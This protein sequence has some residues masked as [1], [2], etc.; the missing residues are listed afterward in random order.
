MNRPVAAGLR[1]YRAFARAFPHEFK[2]VYGEEM[3]RAAEDSVDGI[4]R[5]HGLLG[6]FRL[7]AD[8][9]LQIP[10]EY[11]AEL[12]QDVRYGFRML[13]RAP[14]PTAVALLSLTLGIGV[15]ISAFSEMNGFVLRDVPGVEDPSELVMPA[16]PV[17]FPDYRRYRGQSDL[18]SST[19]AYAAPVPFGV[20]LG[21]RTERTWGHLVTPSYFSTLGVRPFLGRLFTADEEQPGRAPTVAVS[22]RFWRNHLGSDPAIVGKT[23]S[24]NG[25][26]CS[27]AGVGP[28][29]F[30]GAS[31]MVYGADLWLP[32]SVGERVAPELAG[33]ALERRDRAILHVVARLRPGVSPPQAEAALDSIARRIEQEEGDPDRHQKGRRITLLPAGKV[34]PVRKQD[35]PFLTSFFTLLGGMILL[36]AS[37]NVANMMLARAADRRKEIAV[38]LALGAGRGRLVRQLLTESMLVAAAAGVLGFAMAVWVMRLASQVKMPYP[39]PL[40]MRLE[41]DGRVLLFTIALTAFTGVAFGLLPALQATRA[42]LTPALKEGGAVRLPRFR[43]LSLRN[44]LV[45]S[46][47]AGS[48]ALLLI[49]GFLVIGHKRMMGT[50]VGFDPQRLLLISLDPVR[51]GYSGGQ[52]A[53]FFDKLLDRIRGL[54]VVAAASLADGAPMT[55]IGK[56]TATFTVSGPGSESAGDRVIHGARRYRVDRYF[57][58]TL[59]VPI[60]RGRGFRKQD[61]SAGAMAAI[62]SEKLIRECWNGQ[63]PLGRRIEIG[64]EYI[65]DFRVAGKPSPGDRGPRM[66]GKP[67]ILEVV[68]VVPNVRDGLNMVAS[69]AP[70]TIYLPLQT[71]DYGRA[72]LH[73]MTL[74]VRSVP[75]ADAVDAVRREIAAID[76]RIAPFSVRAMPEQIGEIML[77]VRA[78]LYTYGF[79]GVFGLILASVGLA[80]VTAYSVA[81]RRREIGIRMA[82]GARGSDVLR[83]VMK[84]GAILVSAGALAGIVAGRAGTRLLSALMS[85][86]AR[87]AGMSMSDP[88]L[89]AGA[90]LL[91]VSL[92]LVACYLPAR[93]SVRIDPVIALRQE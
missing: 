57:F 37:S 32:L 88:L 9:A 90:P 14:G 26:P 59:G 60:L 19:L 7:L 22:F 92:A 62:V 5:R 3:L 63:D 8:I 34:M 78:A 41:P 79:I 70:A 69:E 65:P 54:R 51:D 24:V 2:N 11:L 16:A 15:A 38:R 39:M 12:R 91:L 66:L 13:A 56:P 1:L 81:Q 64:D 4:W 33:D 86:V 71:K 28:E 73:G 31:P 82:L 43:R 74:M 36:I 55:M 35:L 61:E 85:Q 52:S 76:D 44:V 23:L 20:S 83:L 6:L 48:L 46:Q 17:S 30:E 18:F 72:S 25:Q 27:V 77:P 53:A 84:E 50:E 40:T 89:L 45:F 68:G 93:K 67:H 87:T 75:G 42:D 29:G 10:V 49:T 47:V 58:E 21:G 80:G